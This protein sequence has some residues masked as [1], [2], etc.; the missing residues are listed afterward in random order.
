MLKRLLELS[1][2][3]RLYYSIV[4]HIR[5]YLQGFGYC[6]YDPARKIKL[7]AP[8]YVNP[9]PDEAP[10]VERIFRSFKLMKEKQKEADPVY[11]PSEAWQSTLDNAYAHVNDAAKRNDLSDFHMFLANSGCWKSSLG[12]EGGITIVAGSKSPLLN[13]YIRNAMF[14]KPFQVWNWYFGG[15]RDIEHLF[16]PN[17]GNQAGAW[18]NKRFVDANCFQN[19]ILGSIISSSVSDFEKP[20]VADLGGGGGKTA[21]FT[22]RNLKNWSYLDFDLPEVVIVAAYYLMMSFP[23]K[24]LL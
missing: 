22:L 10:V 9:N 16:A 15:R 21:A 17:I 24:K 20:V 23:E 13:R 18:M 14:R 6:F 5:P 7:H 8:Q 11:L 3:G 12:F 1:R 2:E 19:D 4:Q